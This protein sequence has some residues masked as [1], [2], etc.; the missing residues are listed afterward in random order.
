M[1]KHKQNL[2]KALKIGL[3]LTLFSFCGFAYGQTTF[4]KGKVTEEGSQEPV[5]G[6][7]VVVKGT[8]RGTVTD[9]NGAFSIEAKQSE[10]LVISFIGYISK[11]ALIEDL[12]REL[13]ISLEL[14]EAE[15]DEIVVIGYGTQRKSDLTGSVG[16]VGEKALQDRPSASLTQNLSGRVQGV[17]VSVNSGRPGGRAN[18]RIRG[19]TS[20]SIANDPLY[21]IDGVIMHSAGLA[22][23]STP[24]DYI[25]PNDI[26]SIEVLKDASAT[27]IYGARGA[28]GVIMISTKRGSKTGGTI[29]YDGNFSIGVLPKKIP[30]LN[31]SEFLATEDLAYQNAQKYDPNGWA[32]GIY[33]DPKLKRTDP[34]LFDSNG[35]PLYDTDW[36]DESFQ[37]AF[38][39]NHQLSFTGGNQ[40]DSFG[41]YL[42]YRDEDGLMKESWMK[43]F[44]GRFVFDSKIKDWVKVGGGLSYNDQKESQVDPLGNGGIIAMRQVLEALPIIPVRY[45]DGNWAGNADYPGMEGGNNPLHVAKERVY[46]VNTQTMI[47]NIY[48]NFYLAKG[49]ELR[50]NI[51]TNIVNQRVDYYGGRN[52]NYIAKNQGGDASVFNDRLNSWQFENYLTY[53]KTFNENHAISAMAGLSWQHVDRFN[54][55]ARSQN[56]QD[57]YFLFNNLGAGAN[58]IQP[59]SGSVAYGLNSYFSRLNY[60]LNDKYL[61]T[62]TGRVDGSSKF[63]ESNQ[64]AFFPSAAFAWRASDENFLMNSSVVSNLK[65]RSSYGMTG[66]SEITAYQALAGMGNYSV[67]FNNQREIGLGISRLANPD[68]RW[69]KTSQVD[70]G[71][72]LGLFNNRVLFEVDLYRKLTEDMLLSAPVPS[73]SGY[74]VVSQNVGSM[75]NKGIEIGLNTV[76]FEKNNFSW[77]TT[78]NYSYNK[79]VVKELAGGSDI[80]LG[81]TIVRKGEPVGSFFGFVHEGTWS[82]SEESIAASYNKRPGDIKYKDVNEDG[83]IN[84]SDRVVIGKGIPTGFGTFANTFTFNNFE[85]LVDI[86][87][88]YGN[89]VLFRSK[90]SAEDRTGIANSFK[91]V[92]NAWTPE[93]QN[94]NIAQIRP[95]TAGYNTNNDSDRVQDGSFIRGRNL[96]LS[97]NFMPQT[98]EKI[99]VAR[100][101]VYASVQNFFLATDY[102]GYDPEVSTSGA[103]FDQG[104]DLYAYPK[105]RV[106]MVGVSITL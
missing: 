31:S 98:L 60:T 93:N 55:T 102:A 40:D 63:G 68:L 35:N 20:V 21:V 7:L 36:Q 65:F 49:L 97:Y 84:D 13:N 25:N 3:L 101:R 59:Q 105:P 56:F 62:L 43:R 86:Q 53:I 61:F 42:G 82:S 91:T 15:L 79:N 41:A 64:Y 2:R 104:V 96:M 50:S 30:L 77:N 100:M 19:N 32:N 103:A 29:T 54:T 80:F 26:A 28:N 99:S 34:K 33:K 9:A 78:F 75:E 74:T 1:L 24:I 72:E 45:P 46:L 16:S 51:S 39:Q 27:A 58:A 90:H 92:L 87:Y 18:I 57:D 81:S 44:S 88:T 10:R 71:A 89:D 47:G 52:L 8:Q 76:N 6:A 5:A 73:S 48:A 23:G 67:I 37:Q 106:F 70:I 69:E 14:D 22:N 12:S 94:T 4:V 83:V 95:L 85:L 11:E 17:N 38:T 66:N